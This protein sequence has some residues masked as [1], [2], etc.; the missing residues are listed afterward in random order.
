VKV[1]IAAALA[2]ID[3]Y[4]PAV[5]VVFA[6][7]IVPELVIVPP[8]RPVPVALVHDLDRNI[9]AVASQNSLGAANPVFNGFNSQIYW[10]PGADLTVDT[11]RADGGGIFLVRS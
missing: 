2:A 5:T 7:D 11:V 3:P 1:G 8:V 9:Q 10:I 4:V 6:S